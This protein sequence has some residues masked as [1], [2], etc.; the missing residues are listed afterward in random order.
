LTTPLSP[1]ARRRAV[2]KVPRNVGTSQGGVGGAPGVTLVLGGA[3]GVG[4]PVVP[5]GE[6][7]RLAGVRT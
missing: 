6:D 7:T 5:E 1:R 2:S 4:D 3:G